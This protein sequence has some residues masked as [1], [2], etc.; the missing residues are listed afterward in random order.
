MTIARA[1]GTLLACLLAVSL[2]APASHAADPAAGAALAVQCAACHGDDGFSTDEKY[3]NLAA[4]KAGY[5]AAQLTAFRT[6]DRKNALMNAIAADLSDTEIENLAAHFSGLPGAEPGVHGSNET[7]LDGAAVAFP[8]DYE[9]TFK[10]YTRVEFEGRKQVRFYRANQAAIDGAKGGSLEGAYIRVEIFDAKA[11]AAGD[12]ARDADG[13]LIVGDLKAFTAMERRSG[14]GEAVPSIIR[15]GDWRYAVFSAE[16]VPRAKLNEARCL[17][18]H[19]PEAA[20]KYI[21]S[22]QKLRDFAET[23]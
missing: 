1:Q 22:V 17:A 14:N 13:K 19:K 4:Q 7:G 20:N 23:Q 12:L 11:D 2:F 8:A 18:C 5:I 3:P 6:G 21:F 15:N 16:G 9:D 10:R